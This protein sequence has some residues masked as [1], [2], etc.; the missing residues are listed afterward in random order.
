[1]SDKEVARR[2][3]VNPKVSFNRKHPRAI[4]FSLGKGILTF[5]LVSLFWIS[6]KDGVIVNQKKK[7]KKKK[8][9]SNWL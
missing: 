8:K 4:N 1:L 5:G 2:A 7:K 6:L 3:A 9:S